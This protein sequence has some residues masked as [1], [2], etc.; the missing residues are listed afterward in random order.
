MPHYRLRKPDDFQGKEDK[1][2]HQATIEGALADFGHQL[3]LILELDGA[4]MNYV[5][6]ER[7]EGESNFKNAESWPV[8]IAKAQ[9]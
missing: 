4:V 6:Y 1:H 7:P 9:T 2:C 3:G 5:L 8:S